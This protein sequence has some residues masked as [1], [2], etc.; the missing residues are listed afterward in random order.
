MNE[1]ELISQT[2][3]LRLQF[4]VD[5]T[6]PVDVFALARGISGLTLV[7]YPMGE[8]LSGM[9]IKI[10]GGLCLIA[11]NSSMSLGRQRF[12][13]AH[14]FFHEFYDKNT[15]AICAKTI[16]DRWGKEIE[17]QADFFASHFLMPQPSLD[18]MVRQLSERHGGGRL[19]LEDIVRIEQH[20]G[21]SHRAAMLRLK[22]F[23]PSVLFEAFYNDVK[24]CS[25]AE[26][27]GFDGELYRPSLENKKYGCYGE[28]VNMAKQLLD[29]GKIS[30]GKYEELLLDGF[31]SDLVYG[32]GENAVYELD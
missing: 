31:R 1:L 23:L 22:K 18:I 9:C 19:D 16:F 5:E 20:F 32:M 14:E 21:V 3:Q 26:R 29:K 10:D 28:Y 17:Q 27:L 13:L 2:T 11:I 7:F 12:S 15:A 24:I 25:V 4:G 30:D 6:L 8:R